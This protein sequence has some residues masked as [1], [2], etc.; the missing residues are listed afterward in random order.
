MYNQ[1]AVKS[2][3][4]SITTEDNTMTT[5]P[6]CANTVLLTNAELPHLNSEQ[7]AI[8]AKSAAALISRSTED[9][10]MN[11]QDMF[12]FRTNL[13]LDMANTDVDSTHYAD[14]ELTLH[15]VDTSIYREIAILQEREAGDVS[16]YENDHG[17][18]QMEAYGIDEPTETDIV[19][20]WE[21]EAAQHN[22]D[23]DMLEWA[24]GEAKGYAAEEA[25]MARDIQE[26]AD[27]LPNMPF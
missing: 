22:W 21:D 17:M 19:A 26:Y 8:Y 20:E 13:T 6:T 9:N 24:A 11:L 3:T 12:D 5:I 14:M 1:S 16:S 18:S 25:K 27:S 23:D 10:T 2:I 4:T 7:Y 15:E